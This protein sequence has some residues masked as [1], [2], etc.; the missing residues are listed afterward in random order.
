MVALDSQL[1]QID[2]DHDRFAGRY[3]VVQCHAC[4][5]SMALIFYTY[6]YNIIRTVSIQ[7]R[8]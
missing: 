8:E 5:T 7:V 1:Q 2:I 6:R 4:T 3:A